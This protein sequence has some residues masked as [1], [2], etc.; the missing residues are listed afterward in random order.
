MMPRPSWAVRAANWKAM[1]N[2]QREET[3]ECM[4]TREEERL[5][6]LKALLEK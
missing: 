6:L 1:E 2:A 3:W 5:V 4:T